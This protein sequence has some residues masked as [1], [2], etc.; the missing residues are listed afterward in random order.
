MEYNS[1]RNKKIT[2]SSRSKSHSN[3]PKSAEEGKGEY[4]TISANSSSGQNAALQRLHLLQ[5]QGRKEW[6][7]IRSECV[8]RPG[9][10]TLL[11]RQRF[12]PQTDLQKENDRQNKMLHWVFK[13]LQEL[14]F[15]R[16]KNDG[17]RN[18]TMSPI[19]KT[20]SS[21]TTAGANSTATRFGKA[22]GIVFGS[23]KQPKIPSVKP[24]Q[25]FVTFKPIKEHQVVSGPLSSYLFSRGFCTDYTEL[26]YKLLKC[27]S[28]L[29]RSTLE[30]LG[31][32]YTESHD[33]NI[34]WISSSTKPYLYDGLNEYQK[35]NH[36]P[37]S[38]EITRKDKLCINLL[39][40]Q[41]KFG[42]DN[43]HIAPD[44][45]LL[46]DEFADFYEEYQKMRNSEPRK[47]LWV[48]KPN[49]SSQGKGI[50]L[51]DDVN[52]I[53]LD[54][55]CVISKYIPNPLLI[56]GHK[57]DLRIYVLVT[58]WD[59]LR[60]YVYKEGLTRFASEEFSTSS[61]KKSRFIHLT[62][63]SLNKKNANWKT[64]EDSQR[65]DFGFKWS[66]T[67][68]CQHLERIGIDMDLLWSKIYDVI[69]KSFVL[70]ET[71]IINS[72]KRNCSYR[73]NC[74][75]L[76]GF[77]ILIDSDLKPWLI[78]INLSPSLSADSP[79]DFKIKTNLISD[80]LNL[81]G[82]MKFDRKKEKG[83]HKEDEE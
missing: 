38:S 82:L 73:T 10:C 32:N 61:N 76:Y 57:F 22:D 2:G 64:N 15:N 66:I 51:I 5:R 62:N 80:T 25:E 12:F 58:S 72:M 46:P 18:R 50:Y 52:E 29:M 54:D 9:T 28:R 49:A 31:F 45:Y 53:N 7:G 3:H 19:S 34:L 27:E 68:L 40:I 6:K 33:W 24:Y 17:A 56:N 1:K 44:T 42:K 78:E 70:G 71:P 41:E 83:K 65:D 55:S 16:K 14:D 8:G 36:F 47:P 67:A 60:V 39:K 11:N 30:S 23:T 37:A 21:M 77:D 48:I 20:N 81:V 69:I 59:P 63:Y 35:I 75:E 79:L 13:K 74:F 43:F 4:A 26:S